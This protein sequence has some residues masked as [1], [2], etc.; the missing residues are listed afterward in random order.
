MQNVPGEGMDLLHAP[1]L[2]EARGL[3]KTYRSDGADNPALRG[4]DLTVAGGEFVAIMGRSGCGKSTLLNLLAGLDRP[5]EGS[6]RVAGLHLGSLNETQL[7]LFRRRHV[8]FVFQA[9]HLLHNLDV[10]TNVELPALLA[11]MPARQARQRCQALLAGLG[12]DD[13]A[14]KVPARLSG[15][16]KQRVALARALVNRPTLLLADEPTGSLDQQTGR[17]VAD[18]LR[19]INATGQ[20]IVLVTHDPAI[21]AVARRV[22][23]MQDGRIID[24]LVPAETN[25]LAAAVAR[26]LRL[27]G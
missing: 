21:A 17:Q 18:L 7:A 3:V 15:G 16:E 9:F 11:G 5:D 23:V 22:L 25:D 12:V 19:R 4:V 10:Q 6:V 24:E 2:V 13:A 20:T 27:V 1:P 8:G 14:A 26:L